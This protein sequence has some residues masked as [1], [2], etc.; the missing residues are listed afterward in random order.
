[1]KQTGE[2]DK[3]DL[4]N[5]NGGQGGGQTGRQMGGQTGRQTGGHWVGHLPPLVMHVVYRFDTGGLE[6]GV[7]NLINHLPLDAFRHV[8][9]ALSV[10]TDF[11]QRVHRPDVE[12][13]ALNKPSGHGVKLYPRLSQLFRQFRPA[14]VHT[15]NLAA[16]EATVPAWF[17]GVPV[18]IH[19]E[20]GRDVDDLD[21]N[22]RKY[23]WMRRMYRPWVSH[24]VAL[25][26][27]LA[28]YIEHRV[29]VPRQRISQIY[30]GVDVQLFRPALEPQPIPGCPFN[31]A[32]HWIVG[33]VGRMQQ[34]KDPV[35]LAQAFVRTLE[36]APAL[37][38][39]LR[40]VMVGDGPMRAPTQALLDSAGVGDLAWLPG[41]RKDIATVMQGL[42]AF[43]LPSRA[44][45]VSN[46]ILEAMACGLPVV[47]TAVGGNPELVADGRTGRLVASRDVAGMADCIARWSAQPDL[48]ASMGR[49]GRAEVEAR[50]SLEAM[51]E[52][53]RRLYAD[54][55]AACVNRG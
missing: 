4:N 47:A 19:G 17:A 48:A 41:E 42:N 3:T 6:N 27:D 50:F 20:H 7:V 49:A 38:T 18:R 9:V 37:R 13:I 21:G 36:L 29:G 40:L 31:T 5:S 12:F 46:T 52:A 34:V 44:E 2:S 32:N 51:V 45:G 55:L 35:L 22:R 26:Q 24:Y 25:S 15:R 33:T 28:G 11:R 30:N 1:M 16:L 43:V 10:V 53:Y 14:I 23:Q 54:R 39:R 8:V